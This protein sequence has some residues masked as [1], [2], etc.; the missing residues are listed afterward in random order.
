[1]LVELGNVTSYLDETA[2]SGTKYYYEVS[3]KSIVGEG[4]RSNEASATNTSIVGKWILVSWLQA[5][6]LI[7]M[8]DTWL[9]FNADG[10]MASC[11]QGTSGTST[12][13]DLG[14]GAI[15]WGTPPATTQYSI[16]G[17]TLVLQGYTT[18]THVWVVLTLTRA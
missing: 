7:Q 17:N 3:A 14:N 5:G 15:E 9:Q 2:S 12:W 18:D 8:N 16:N 11:Q 10:T 1:M 4:N 6:N 13:R